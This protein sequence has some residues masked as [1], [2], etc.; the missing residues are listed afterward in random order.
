[1]SLQGWSETLVTAQADGAALTNSTTA[2]SI[3]PAGAKFTLPANFFQIGKA[4]R[5]TSRGRISNVVTTPGTLTLDVRLGAVIAFTTQVIALNIV[6]K[7]NVTFEFET[8][9]TC[10]AIGQSTTANL[11]GV[12]TFTSESVVGAAAGTALTMMCPA[13][14]PAVGTGFDS[15]TSLAVDHFATFSVNTATTSLT[16]HEYVL[17]ALN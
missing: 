4:V 3:I 8:I 12:G 7:T 1:M 14:A 13:T 6:A 9:L 10:R 5:L 11:M 2:T 16:L 17:E 15:T